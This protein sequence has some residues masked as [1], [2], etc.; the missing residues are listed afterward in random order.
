VRRLEGGFVVGGMFRLPWVGKL[1]VSSAIDA[2]T[3][4]W[5]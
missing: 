1:N 5:A 2:V 4:R 3:R